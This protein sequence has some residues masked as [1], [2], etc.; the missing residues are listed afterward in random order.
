MILDTL[1]AQPMIFVAW[2]IAILISL[3]IHEFAHAFF[4]VRQ[5]DPTPQLLGR[6]SLNPLRHVD[7][8]G[9]LMLILVGFGWGKPVQV[10]PVYFKNRKWGEAIVS[11]AGPLMNAFLA[12][13]F[14]IILKLVWMHGGYAEN[15]LMI[16]FL[17]NLVIINIVLCLFNLIPIPPLDGSHVLFSLL[18]SS[19][20]DFKHK[21]SVYGPR[22]LMIVV[23]IDIFFNIGIFSSLFNSFLNFAT[24][25]IFTR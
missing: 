23:F 10:N 1:F 9:F 3:S 8:L 16:I 19:F 6:V 13:F 22:F 25:L 4:A 12:I 7:A 24:N 5:G 21:L 18:P 11:V 20:D 17:Y 14:G 2:V 15:N